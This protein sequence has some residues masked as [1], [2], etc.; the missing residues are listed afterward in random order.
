MARNQEQY[1]GERT[2]CLWKCQRSLIHVYQDTLASE[3]YEDNSVY[4]REQE[5][6]LVTVDDNL[7]S[8]LKLVLT[9]L[10]FLKASGE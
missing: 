1:F 2:I 9:L 7:A 6:F 10:F 5:D 8:T 3:A 4:L